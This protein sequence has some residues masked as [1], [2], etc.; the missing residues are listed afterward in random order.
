MWRF[1]EEEDRHGGKKIR[2]LPRFCFY[3]TASEPRWIYMAAQSCITTFTPQFLSR[4]ALFETHRFPAHNYLHCTDRSFLW[5]QSSSLFILIHRLAGLY[6]RRSPVQPSAQ[7][8]IRQLAITQ[9]ILHCPQLCFYFPPES[10]VY[11]AHT[12]RHQI[13]SCGSSL[14]SPTT[15]QLSPPLQNNSLFFIQFCHLFLVFSLITWL[16]ICSW[17][18]SP[19]HS[20]LS[21]SRL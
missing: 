3:N 13:S 4:L 15:R 14:L 10:S 1:T 7:S 18:P 9:D 20:N 16:H 12:N 11:Q 8:E 2:F 19:Q 17:L 6:L 5:V 21:I